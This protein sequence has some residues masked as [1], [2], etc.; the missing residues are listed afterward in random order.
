MRPK[1][2]WDELRHIP[3][4]SDEVLQALATLS[5]AQIYNLGS[6]KRERGP[7]SSAR[8]DNVSRPLDMPRRA[9]FP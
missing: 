1:M 4:E 9:R 3:D 7:V 2:C 8:L 5:Q 6:G